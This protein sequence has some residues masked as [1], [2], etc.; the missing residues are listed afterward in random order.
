MLSSGLLWALQLGQQQWPVM[1]QGNPLL[2]GGMQMA[3]QQQ[4]QSLM[5]SAYPGSYPQP[6][7]YPMGDLNM[8]QRGHL[9]D[10]Q[11]AGSAER[12]EQHPGHLLST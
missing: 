5:A 10:K 8:S 1:G 2:G 3:V 6:G 11:L 9:H 4:M 7:Q 12:Q